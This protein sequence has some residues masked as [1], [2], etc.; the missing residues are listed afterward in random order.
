MIWGDEP[1]FLNERE[2]NLLAQQ[3]R[4]TNPHARH[5]PTMMPSIHAI[6]QSGNLY[7]YVMHNPVR[8]ADPTGLAALDLIYKC[9]KGLEGSQFG[10]GIVVKKRGGFFRG[11]FSGSFSNRSTSGSR[12]FT[13]GT[14]RGATVTTNTRTTNITRGDHATIRALE[15]R[16]VNTT[17]N[18]VQRARPADILVQSDGRW[19][20][21]GQG[22]R[23]H[24]LE[25]GG[26]I[27]TTMN[28]VTN[29]NVLKKI[30]SGEWSR[31]TLEQQSTFM[32]MF[33]NYVNWPA[34]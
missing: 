12:F 6:L 15:G 4:V 19:I 2:A 27:V 32:E 13:R 31:L 33:S 18:D 5:S 14:G 25:F 11:R 21:R 9:K 28:Q 17:I 29:A 1:A 30:N 3:L 16:N 24:V 7:M 10:G 8:F 34:Q 20:V 23:V 22:G 26:E